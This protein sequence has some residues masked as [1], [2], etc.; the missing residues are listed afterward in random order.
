MNLCSYFGLAVRKHRECLG[1]SQ[2]DLADKAELDRTYISDI[3]RGRRN[4]SLSSIARLA[5]ALG[6]SLDM[7]FATVEEIKKTDKRKEL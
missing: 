1:W 6:V 7:L 4:P 5:D 2:E 3:E